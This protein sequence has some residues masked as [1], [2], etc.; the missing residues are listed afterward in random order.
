VVKNLFPKPLFLKTFKYVPILPPPPP[1]I[2]VFFRDEIV[3]YHNVCSLTV[4]DNKS[5][6]YT[7]RITLIKKIT[8]FFVSPLR[9]FVFKI[10]PSF[11]LYSFSTRT[12]ILSITIISFYTFLSSCKATNLI[13]NH[14]KYVLSFLI[15]SLSTNMMIYSLN[16]ALF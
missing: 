15:N 6:N 13:R 5:L 11:H 9:F 1:I 10:Y 7:V 12:L 14:F 2:V 8:N 16:S 4:D 3:K